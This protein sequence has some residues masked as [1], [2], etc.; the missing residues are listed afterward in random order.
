MRP[1][2]ALN[3]EQELAD[4]IGVFFR[5]SVNDGS[6]EAYEFTEINRSGCAGASFAGGRWGRPDDTAGVALVVNG[7]SAAARNY[8]AAGGLGILIGDGA[9]RNYGLEKIVESYY[10]ISPGPKWTLSADLQ[11]V[12]HPAYNRERGPVTV[13]GLRLHWS[14]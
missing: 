7:I 8:L 13:I 3:F 2:A 5:G 11:F 12:D 14:S 9:L 10:S 6:H 1:G 4:G